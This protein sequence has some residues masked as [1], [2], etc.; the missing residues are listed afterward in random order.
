MMK[1]QKDD[2]G[3]RFLVVNGPNLN[4]LGEREPSVYGRVTL[5]EIEMACRAWGTGHGV[6]VSC[7]QS[8]SEGALLDFLHAERGTATGVVLNPAAYTHTSVALRDGVAALTIPVVEVH[9]SNPG[10]RESFRAKSLIA[11]V[12]RGTIAGFGPQGYL[13][14][15][16]ALEAMT[17]GVGWWP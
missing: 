6:D 9:L 5:G 3:R 17:S 11:P 13:L 8:N 16:E 10:A 2:Q 14:A 7:F 4:L 15:L 12:T 1:K